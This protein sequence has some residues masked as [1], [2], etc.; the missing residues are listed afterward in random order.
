MTTY[1]QQR[2]F[3]C[4]RRFKNRQAIRGHIKFCTREIPGIVFQHTCGSLFIAG[5]I[6]IP[7]ECK[8]CGDT[9]EN[10]WEE[11]GYTYHKRWAHIPQGE[12]VE[13]LPPEIAMQIDPREMYREAGE[14]YR[15]EARKKK[16]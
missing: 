7:K 9:Y 12:Y 10:E 5:G 15:L 4:G 16:K 14:Y 13:L 6:M 8:F 3:G 2:C 11:I 1:P